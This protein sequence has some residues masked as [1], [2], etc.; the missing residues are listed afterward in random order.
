VNS[1]NGGEKLAKQLK[2]KISGCDYIHGGLDQNLRTTIFG[3]FKDGKIDI[4]L[5]TDVA[6]RGLD[7]AKVTH[8]VNYDMPRNRE[9]YTHRTGRAGR[10]GRE[11]T[12]LTMVT[13]RELGDCKRLLV[14]LKMDA[15]WDGDAPNLDARNLEE[16]DK[17]INPRKTKPRFVHEGHSRSTV[18]NSKRPP[19]KRPPSK[20]KGRKPSS[21]GNKPSDQGS[22]GPSS[23]GNSNS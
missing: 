18:E 21:H 4:L 6:G 8:V 9:S 12:A 20:H 3:K 5:A 1:R 2:E 15:I 7:F 17:R 22:S 16:T 13:P 14:A 11:G 19:A 10:M 23:E